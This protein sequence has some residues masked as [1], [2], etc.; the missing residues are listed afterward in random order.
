MFSYQLANLRRLENISR[1]H[2]RALKNLETEATSY[3]N[4][5]NVHISIGEYEKARGPIEK[6]L[7]ISK[8][9]GDRNKEAACYT[10]L[11]NVHISVGEYEKARKYF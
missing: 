3:T 1:N 11:G 10:N 2:S 9:L 8:E 6:S 4:L 5:G 7:A